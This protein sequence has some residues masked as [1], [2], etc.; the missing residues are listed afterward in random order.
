MAAFRV[1]DM[2][3]RSCV[4]VVVVGFFFRLLFSLLV[5]LS[6]C[7]RVEQYIVPTGEIRPLGTLV[8]GTYLFAK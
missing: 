8:I 1:E 2:E 4:V 5:L 6:I 7:G 3:T